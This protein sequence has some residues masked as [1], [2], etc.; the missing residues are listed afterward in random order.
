LSNKTIQP[1]FG[2]R[3]NEDFDPRARPPVTPIRS[4]GVQEHLI[5][6]GLDEEGVTS[7]VGGGWV[8]FLVKREHSF[9]DANDC[10]CLPSRPPGGILTAGLIAR[11]SQVPSAKLCVEQSVASRLPEGMSRL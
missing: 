11:N 9:L 8:S 1:V 7:L 5:V 10:V 3:V 4:R 6:A 2:P